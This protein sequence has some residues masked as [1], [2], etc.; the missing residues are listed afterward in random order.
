MK[1]ALVTHSD[2]RGGA[3]VVT[4]RLAH[5][6]RGCGVDAVV[7]SANAETGDPLV[8]PLAPPSAVRMAFLAEHIDIFRHRGVG[9]DNLFKISTA[10]AGLPLWRHP[11][12]TDADAVVL[13]WVNQGTVSLRGIRRL[14][15]A[16]PG[17]PILWVM[18]DLWNAAGICH[19]TVDGCDRLTGVCGACPLLH[20]RPRHTDLST[21]T[22]AAKKALYGA[23]PIRFVAVSN[24][25]AG[26]CRA[27]SLMRDADISVVPNA[28]P[29]EEF[30]PA[31]EAASIPGVPDGTRVIIMG[32]ARLDDPVKNLPLAVEALNAVATPD[33]FAVF[34]GDIRDAHALDGLHMPHAALGRVDM[35]TLPALYRR[36]DIVLS[37]SRH[38]TLPGTLIEGISCGA[39]AVATSHGGQ[40][41][42]VTD[43][44]LGTLCPDDAAAIAA[45]IDAQLASRAACKDAAADRGAMHAAMAGR[46][47]AEAVARRILA[48]LPGPTQGRGK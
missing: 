27:S 7:L 46:F 34:F 13:G 22:Q 14:H 30:T 18:H 24:W 25:L 47:A 39:R 35:R 48:L 32:A 37:T 16:F 19:H 10:T 42:I 28:F 17:K 3:A 11:D 2:S 38:E 43:D 23:V 5:A 40:P 6:L 12:I 41:D 21:R 45:A 8:K 44:T 1:I 4:M 20:G 29:V 9:R 33:T 26:R 31:G 15:A 36:A